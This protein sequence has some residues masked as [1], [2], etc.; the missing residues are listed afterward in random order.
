MRLDAS[1]DA[2]AHTPNT[3]LDDA[4]VELRREPFEFGALPASRVAP[5][6]D[7]PAALV[8]TQRRLLAAAVPVGAGSASSAT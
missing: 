6:A 2:Y 5:T 4:F 7:T 1:A 8:P 3:E